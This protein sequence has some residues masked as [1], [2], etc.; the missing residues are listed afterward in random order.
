MPG[1]AATADLPEQVLLVEIVEEAAHRQNFTLAPPGR[2]SQEIRARPSCLPQGAHGVA[3]LLYVHSLGPSSGHRDRGIRVGGQSSPERLIDLV[4]R[5][6]K[7]EDVDGL[8]RCGHCDR[9]AARAAEY[10]APA[11]ED[12]APAAGAGVK[13]TTVPLENEA[14]FGAAGDAGGIESTRRYRS[15]R[16]QACHAPS[17]GG[18]QDPVGACKG[19]TRASTLGWAC[20]RSNRDGPGDVETRVCKVTYIGLGDRLNQG[21]TCRTD[22]RFE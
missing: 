13:V 18:G 22:Q 1:D 17:A 7:L 14:A 2:E 15:V 20:R 10:T 6:P 5:G 21:P 19:R 3:Q 8:E 4:Q 16:M 12:L 9:A 11:S